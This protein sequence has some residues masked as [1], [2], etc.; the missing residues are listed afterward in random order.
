MKNVLKWRKGR[1]FQLQLRFQN[2]SAFLD[3][4]IEGGATEGGQ[5]SHSIAVKHCLMFAYFT[6]TERARVHK[7]LFGLRFF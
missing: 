2:E 5:T 7:R 6:F 1:F 4:M 3:R